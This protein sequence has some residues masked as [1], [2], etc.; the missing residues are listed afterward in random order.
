MI[1]HLNKYNNQL[2]TN[3]ILNKLRKIKKLNPMKAVNNR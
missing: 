3:L 1:L 2:M